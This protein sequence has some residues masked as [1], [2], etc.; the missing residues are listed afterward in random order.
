MTYYVSMSL[1][2]LERLFSKFLGSQWDKSTP[3]LA[4]SKMLPLILDCVHWTPTDLGPFSLEHWRVDVAWFKSGIAQWSC[5]RVNKK[6]WSWNFLGNI[7]H[8]H[9]FL[10]MSSHDS[11]LI[12]NLLCCLIVVSMRSGNASQIAA[13]AKVHGGGQHHVTFVVK[14]CSLN[15][16]YVKQTRFWH[17]VLTLAFDLVPSS[18]KKPG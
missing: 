18:T 8:S 7:F 15:G 9:E 10:T 5:N 6:F 12:E 1:F 3:Y 16:S 4:T 2:T 14:S 13:F 17:K 11:L